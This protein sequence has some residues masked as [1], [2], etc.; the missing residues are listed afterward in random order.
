[1]IQLAYILS[2]SHSGSTMLA[3]LLGAHPEI[4]TAGE[5]K[6]TA[7]G[8]VERY[9]CSCGNFIRQCDFWNRVCERMA[10]QGINFDIANAQTN[11][12]S[13]HSDYV[14]KLLRP[15][16]R[17]KI[18]ELARDAA[19]ALSPAWHRGLPRMQRINALLAD[20]LIRQSGASVLVDSSK[21]A[22]RLKYLLRN[23]AFDVRVIRLIRDGRG[24]A[25]TYM[26]PARFADAC[27]PTRRGGGSGGDRAAER[28]ELRKAAHEWKRSNEEAEAL[29]S[30]LAP[31]QQ[32]RVHYEELCREPRA[33]LMRLARFLGVDPEQV[34]LDFRRVEQHVV[35]NGMRLDTTSEIVLDE[36][37][38]EIL[39]PHDLAEF[40]AVAGTMNWAY[41]YR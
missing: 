21:V 25:L 41:G 3:M 1:M 23:P 26:D 20:C 16:H 31:H 36:R 32:I 4:C 5:L 9:R 17:G 34:T 29:L 19:L 12:H 13:I 2:A 11:F 33:T 8:D 38:R 10:Q 18:L 40:D 30:S 14:Q 35:G 28:L 39:T 37:W 24:V 6:A 22:L 27:D 15:L 7:L